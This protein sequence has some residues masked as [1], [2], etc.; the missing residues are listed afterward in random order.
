MTKPELALLPPKTMVNTSDLSSALG[1]APRTLR[2]MVNAGT[3]PPPIRIGGGN[4][5]F[6]GAV[7]QHFEALAAKEADE[8]KRK[9]SQIAQAMP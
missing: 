2:R 1:V 5:W 4:A 7:I 6:A 8:A 3:L 9:A